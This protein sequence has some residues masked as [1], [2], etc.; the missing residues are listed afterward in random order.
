VK[1][2]ISKY[3]ATK[4]TV[5]GHSLGGAIA[6]IST[7]HL[8]V[9]LPSSISFRTITYSAPRVGNQAFVDFVNA[10]SVMNRVTYK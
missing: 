9:N 1:T 6:V 10:R 8:A 7:A 2:G 4:V 3:G 5:T